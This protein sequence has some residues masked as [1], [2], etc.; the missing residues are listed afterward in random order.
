[1][2]HTTI[3]L[4]GNGF[5]IAHGLPTQ[6]IDFLH[7]INLFMN[8]K[9]YNDTFV[10]FYEK[11]IKSYGCKEIVKEYII[12]IYDKTDFSN[13]DK[14]PPVHLVHL[15]KQI[16]SYDQCVD[17]SA[18]FN[19]EHNFWYKYFN[20]KKHILAGWVDF[21][22]EM[23]KVI[24]NI[25]RI[26][27]CIELRKIEDISSDLI[28]LMVYVMDMHDNHNKHMNDCYNTNRPKLTF[29]PESFDVDN[30]AIYQNYLVMQLTNFIKGLELYLRIF[31][32][33]QDIGVISPEIDTVVNGVGFDY[34]LNFNYTNTFL[35]VY[36]NCV[37]KTKYCQIHGETNYEDPNQVCNMILGID[38]YLD[39]SESSKDTF[40]IPF[41]KFYQRIHKETDFNYINWIEEIEKID[42][43]FLYI[44]VHSLD[45]TDKDIL[46]KFICIERM[47]T[48]I[49]YHDETA[50]GSQIE[51]LVKVLGK[52][53]F[54]KKFHSKEI[55]FLKQSDMK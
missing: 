2:R 27:T 6:Y 49:Y 14:E 28:E 33:N 10:K 43:K 12:S 51:N 53:T 34:I 37:N 38:D 29:N 45:V 17:Y 30:F 26:K 24:Q 18:F 32:E 9:N 39:D 40:C 35:K 46:E 52:E 7:F 42:N 11:I 1:M 13:P 16:N 55:V 25:H 22:S 15:F 20:N 54:L 48:A 41:K 44:F 50:F 31:V 3:L 19:L 47:R 5:D 23:S 21:E 36:S 8:M 4:I